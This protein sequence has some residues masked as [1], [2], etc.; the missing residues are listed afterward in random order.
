MVLYKHSD[1]PKSN[2]PISSSLFSQ[3]Q[4]D[5]LTGKLKPGQ[6]L[7]EQAICKEY[8]VSR[9]PVREALRQLEMDGLV[10]NILNR[11][12]F[13]IGLSEQ[14]FK[15][16]F[17]LRKIYEVQAVKWAI[18]RITDE[19]MDALEE[20]FEFME[21]YTLRNDVDKMLTIN[22]GFHQII[23]EASHNRML[24]QLL[25][26][27]QTYFKY[28][29]EEDIY[30]KNYLTEVLEEH[31]LIFKAFTEKDVEAGAEAMERHITN[32]KKRRC[33]QLDNMI[34]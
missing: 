21:F 18:E 34:K 24:R 26:S 13:V 27:Y 12:S 31:R 29:S 33:K 1:E 28:R 9:T 19:E 25:S 16:M 10:E 17:Q 14:D 6:K 2:A 15:D 3:L 7:T 11:G 22:A 20:T 32:S 23:Y 5:I 30:A 8:K 4:K